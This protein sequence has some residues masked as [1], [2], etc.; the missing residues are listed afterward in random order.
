VAASRSQSAEWSEYFAKKGAAPG[1][2]ASYVKDPIELEA[3][4][5]FFAWAAWAASANRPGKDYS[6]TSPTSAL[7]GEFLLILWPKARLFNIGFL[8][9]RNSD[10]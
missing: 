9:G 8:K 7:E 4:S 6:Y 5:A 1:L 2:P 10:E 3:L